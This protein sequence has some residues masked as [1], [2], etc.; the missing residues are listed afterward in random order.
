MVVAAVHRAAA[1]AAV[2][3]EGVDDTIV[4]GIQ[5]LPRDMT[6]KL[7]AITPTG[8]LFSVGLKV[9]SDR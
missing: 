5:W 6:E 8:S 4:I 1:E 9:Y 7:K 3:G 2:A